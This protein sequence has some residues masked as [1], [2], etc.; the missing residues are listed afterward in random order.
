MQHCTICGF[1]KSF[2]L[3]QTQC[4]ACGTW[5]SMQPGPTPTQGFTFRGGIAF[6]FNNSPPSSKKPTREQLEAKRK[7][8]AKQRKQEELA[9][10]KLET[11][12]KR[13]LPGSSL[14]GNSQDFPPQKNRRLE[15]STS[16]PQLDLGVATWNINHFNKAEEKKASI[17]RLFSENPWLD[18]LVLQE[19]NETGKKELEGM[20]LEGHGLTCLYGPKMLSL[21]PQEDDDEE[22]EIK[23]G[24]SEWYPVIFRNGSG[25]TP[26]K[27]WYYSNFEA[28]D[29]DEDE[30][31]ADPINWAKPVEKARKTKKS[32]KQLDEKTREERKQ[33][34][35]LEYESLNEQYA[36]HRPV[37][38]YD[39]KVSGHVV[40]LAVVHTTPQG[41]DLGRKG[42]YEQVEPFFQHIRE[43]EDGFWIVAGDYYIDPEASVTV[44]SGGKRRK[45]AD[46]FKTVISEFNMDV[47]VPLSAT[48]QSKVRKLTLPKDFSEKGYVEDYIQYEPLKFAV[49]KRADFFVVTKDF[50]H[51]RAGLL[52]PSG[53]ILLVDPNHRALDWWMKVSDHTPVGGIF[54][55]SPLSKKWLL[56]QSILDRLIGD[57]RLKAQLELW[58]FHKVSVDELQGSYRQLVWLISQLEGGHQ[59]L[60]QWLGARVNE[61][62]VEAQRF[63]F[64]W[65]VDE[66]YEHWRKQ[67]QG[68]SQ[69]MIDEFLHI[70]STLGTLEAINMRSPVGDLL[71]LFRRLY[72]ALQRLS[73]RFESYDLIPEKETYSGISA[74]R[75]PATKPPL[76]NQLSL[77]SP[78]PSSNS[79]SPDPKAL[80]KLL[81]QY[82]HQLK[83]EENPSPLQV[84]NA[85][86]VTGTTNQFRVPGGNSACSPM[87]TLAIA[88]LM[89]GGTPSR[90][91]IDTVLIQGTAG[92]Q[93]MRQTTHEMQDLMKAIALSLSQEVDPVLLQP[94]SPHYNPQEIPD[95]LLEQHA[96]VRDNGESVTRSGLVGRVMKLLS[97]Q[98]RI[99]VALVIGG[100]TVAVTRVEGLYYLFDSHGWRD[101]RSA[102]FAQVKGEFG[103][104]NLL[105]N[106]L[107]KMVDDRLVGNGTIGLTVFTPAGSSN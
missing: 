76:S 10:K 11:I 43:Q 29:H 23:D 66:H 61:A 81:I 56:N 32:W 9:R 104:F 96:L 64:E 1:Q 84:A 50:S 71:L 53:G 69:Q 47:T 35:T 80:A 42:E 105:T 103:L 12:K 77:G 16:A 39:W 26:H 40:H 68:I 8:E 4:P 101:L 82:L 51:R 102:F 78:S 85:T 100:F 25:L 88:A 49:N 63:G 27:T 24:Q 14:F 31:D 97:R 93:L 5:G 72:R 30:E 75:F 65:P 7:R 106:W 21:Y 73:L 6:T 45:L 13:K 74:T 17:C 90:E 48:N 57:R 33:A 20:N 83:A 34:L 3:K 46:L 98:T 79:S 62:L 99:G 94:E 37:V 95:E 15:D 70:C 44:G 107:L 87:A 67:S 91:L 86:V 41:N 52:G 36:L 38:V 60:A 58:D 22:W 55:T 59:R 28:Y 19:I 18:V 2:M 54:G 92:Y 89:N